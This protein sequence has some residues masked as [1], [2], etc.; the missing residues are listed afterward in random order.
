[1]KK[2]GFAIHSILKTLILSLVCL[3]TTL[4]GFQDVYGHEV[5]KG[6]IVLLAIKGG[7]GQVFATGTGFIADPEGSVISNYHVL[8]DARSIDAVFQDGR[9]VP[10]KGIYKVDRAKDF[11]ILQL[12]EGLY[13]TLEIGDS[14]QV[15]DFDYTSALGYLSQEVD[16]NGNAV[17]GSI[18]QTYG[19]VSG[20]HPQAYPDFSVIYTSTPFG[21]G[22]SGGPLV[23]QK[24]QVIGVAT[25]EG[26]GVNFALPINDVKPYLNHKKMM[27]FSQLQEEDKHSKEYLYFKGHLAL[28][29]SGDL[30]Q[31]TDYFE[32]ALAADPNYILAHYDLAVIYRDMGIMVE[33]TIGQYEKV[34][35][36]NPRFPEALSNLG[37]HYFRVGKIEEAL[38]LFRQAIQVYPNFIQALSNLGAVLNKVGK[39]NEAIPYLKR[40]IQVDPEFAIAHFNLGNAYFNINQYAKAKVSYQKAADFGLDFLSLHWKLYEIHKREG[41]P[42][43]AIKELRF[44]LQLDPEN[45][46]ARKKLDEMAPARGN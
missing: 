33:K 14:D 23:N 40:T 27:T 5:N 22:F 39:P 17:S 31:A 9:K 25:V 11:C 4:S 16:I 36:L 1:M 26:R 6:A 45:P 13:S 37:G 30:E 18:R 43:K 46:K 19:F 10:V 3:L 12:E 7:D 21:P 38:K 29:G 24:N 44:I 34:I 35:A 28:Y 20:V 32:K 42:Q 2:P 8:I 15:K 41:Q